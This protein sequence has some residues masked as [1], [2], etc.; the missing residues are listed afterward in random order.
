MSKRD[1]Q[2]VAYLTDAEK[3]QLS[4]FVQDSEKTQSEVVR[5]AILEYLDHDR[6]ARVES[7]V[8]DLHDKVDRV[9]DTLDSG[10]SHT[11]MNQ[12]PMNQGSTAVERARDMVRRIQGN[13]EMIIKD[14]D[15]ERV[16]EDN[17]GADDRT[18]RK[19]KQL[20]RKRGLL[21]EHPGERPVWTLESSQWCDW[22]VNYGKLNGEDDTER[23]AQQ[24]PATV[25]RGFD[26]TI[27]VELAEVDSV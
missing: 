13:H 26:D 24:Y 17:A 22:I 12:P 15:V 19:Y 4:Q 3:S 10:D 27:Q 11:H 6:A 8:R 18:I 21:F 20:F 25:T 9:L 2:I 14:D 7:E 5:R 23:V 16:I 1:N